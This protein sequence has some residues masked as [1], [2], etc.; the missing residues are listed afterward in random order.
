LNSAGGIS[1]DNQYKINFSFGPQFIGESFGGNLKLR[2]GYLWA[3]T[4]PKGDV[5]V[6]EV[7]D[8][9]DIVYLINY[10]FYTGSPPVPCVEKGDC[11]CDGIVDIGDIVCLINY[12]FYNGPP[13]CC[14]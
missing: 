11:N 12:V 8:I 6:D 7:I 13:P 2:M 10:V 9:G 1:K 14:G 4:F 3:I 5:N